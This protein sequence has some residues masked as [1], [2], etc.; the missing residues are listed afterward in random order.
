MQLLSRLDA[1]KAVSQVD[2]IRVKTMASL[3]PEIAPA[4]LVQL[5]GGS[6]LS[7][8]TNGDPA[9]GSNKPNVHAASNSGDSLLD[10]DIGEIVK[11]Y[12]LIAI[13]LLA[14]NVVVGLVLL[15]LAVLNCMR[16]GSRR[17]QVIPGTASTDY[18]AV[19][20]DD[21]IYSTNHKGYGE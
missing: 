3:P 18:T 10:G 16:R 4:T 15:V 17:R 20:L 13:I 5:L 7:P 11:K 2:A 14:L 12:G 21:E 19:G 1:P 8:G 6:S 9:T